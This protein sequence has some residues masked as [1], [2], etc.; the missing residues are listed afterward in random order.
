MRL[1]ADC[2]L[3]VRD[4]L[5]EAISIAVR[6]GHGRAL[7]AHLATL[8]V[9]GYMSTEAVEIST[10]RHGWSLLNALQQRMATGEAIAQSTADDAMRRHGYARQLA[11]ETAVDMLGLEGRDCLPPQQRFSARPPM[12]IRRAR[13]A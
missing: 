3:T 12:G 7:S 1:P 8:D 9:I 2:L 5:M 6:D 13:G 4:A 10:G 11:A